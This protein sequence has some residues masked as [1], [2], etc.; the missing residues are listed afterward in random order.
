MSG[1]VRVRGNASECAGASAHGGVIVIEGDASSRAGISLKGGVLVVAG[2]VGR[3]ERLYGPGW[4][5]PRR[6]GRRVIPGRLALRSRH[7]RGR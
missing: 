2:D 6:R 4:D 3:R 5:D 1:A 7:I